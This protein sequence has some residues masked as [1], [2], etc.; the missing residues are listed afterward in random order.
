MALRK[1]AHY[2]CWIQSAALELRNGGSCHMQEKSRDKG[3]PE[4]AFDIPFSGQ[5]RPCPFCG[6]SDLWINSDLD[7]KYVVCKKCSAPTASTVTEAAQR[8]NND[9]RIG[10]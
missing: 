1:L 2:R 5:L 10:R 4:L 9:G 8:W 3:D 6:S 7:P